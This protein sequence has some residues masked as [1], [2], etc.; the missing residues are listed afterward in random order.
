M[1]D[2]LLSCL[3]VT[4]INNAYY[5]FAF[6]ITIMVL[7]GIFLMSKIRYARYGNLLS[8]I[9]I[10]LAI[11]VTLIKN[12]I[13]TTGSLYI[14]VVI[15][16]VI[17]LRVAYKVKMIQMPQLVALLNGSGA[18][19]SAIVGAYSYF[20]IGAGLDM[21]TRVTAII[22]FQ[23]GIIT[24]FGSLIAAGKLHQVIPQAPVILPYHT[25][26][27]IIIF[28]SLICIVICSVNN[29]IADSLFL[30]VSF[31]FS[32]IF[33][34]FFTI[35][36]GGADM[37]ITIS[38]LNSMSGIAGAICGLAIGD[39]L[40]VSIGGIVGASGLLLT[41]IMCW[42]M[43]RNLLDILFGKTTIAAKK[44]S[45]NDIIKGDQS[46]G[47]YKSQANPLEV[48]KNAKDVIIVPGYGMAISQAQHLVKQLSDILIANGAK[49]RFA[50]HPVAGR[51]P[52]H[53]N[54]LLA[55]ANVDYDDLYEIDNINPEFKNADLAIIV[56]ANDVVNPAAREAKDTPIYGMP[57]LNV[58][59][60]KNIF[61]FNYDLKPGYAGVDNPLYIRNEGIYFFLGDAAEQLKKFIDD[62]LLSKVN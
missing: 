31:I 41:Q 8:A 36:I 53:M 54:V 42:A 18:L 9:A 47:V 21:F 57:I 45:D 4:S 7:F 23:V 46:K 11:I 15:G 40:L 49:V 6:F 56:G 2:T 1:N 30:I 62:F 3:S 22:A 38:L 61:V 25:H 12:Q 13:I 28:A 32:L 5:I 58:D 60:C 37:P 17:G 35:R 51:M 24:F 14:F 19:A 16:A 29:I 39:F 43:N 33:G 44:R 10:A 59:E 20:G 26:F 50:I 52:G 55:E 27:S 34:V 48:I